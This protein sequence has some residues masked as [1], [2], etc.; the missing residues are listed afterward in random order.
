MTKMEAFLKPMLSY[1]MPL[2]EG[3]MKAPSAKELVQRPE[4]RPNVS[5]LLGNPLA[6]QIH[7]ISVYN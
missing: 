1:R 6:L 4:I 7:L 5:R 2:I 3:P